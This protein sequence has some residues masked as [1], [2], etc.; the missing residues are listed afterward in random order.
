MIVFQMNR[1]CMSIADGKKTTPVPRRCKIENLQCSTAT[2]L[3]IQ[4]FNDYTIL[5][6]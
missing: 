3:C 2:L 5:G 4:I 1:F 6:K